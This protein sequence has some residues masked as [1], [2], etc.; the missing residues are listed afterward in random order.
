VVKTTNFDHESEIP[1]A[2]S[3][4]RSNILARLFWVLFCETVAFNLTNLTFIATFESLMSKKNPPSDSG[5][6]SQSPDFGGSSDEEE[7]A[8]AEGAAEIPN[9]VAP[10]KIWSWLHIAVSTGNIEKVI[11]PPANL[12]VQL[13]HIAC[14]SKTALMAHGGSR[15]TDAKLQL[16]LISWIVCVAG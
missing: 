3:V 7:A 5:S 10:K 13:G 12:L 4:T 15:P 14:R 6:R 2:A 16:M 8:V 1:L 9:P 11:H